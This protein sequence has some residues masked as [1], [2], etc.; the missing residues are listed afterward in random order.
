MTVLI[1][2]S[3]LAGAIGNTVEWLDFAVYGYFAREIGE[4]FCPADVPSLQQ[5]SAFAVFA[6]ALALQHLSFSYGL[7]VA[8]LGGT[9]PLIATWLE[10][11]L[12]FSQGPALNCLILAVPTLVAYR[13][14]ERHFQPGWQS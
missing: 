13:Q 1:P 14:L 3:T 5:F 7:V 8:L 4:A 10:A 6:V 2:R 11:S 12:G 9:L